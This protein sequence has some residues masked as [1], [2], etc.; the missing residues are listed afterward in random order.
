MTAR[1]LQPAGWPRPRGYSNG[2]VVEGRQVFLSGQVGWDESGRLVGD[3][4]VS[5]LRQALRNIVVL[6]ADAG[7]EP[8]HLVRMTWYLTNMM[9]YRAQQP[10]I[11]AAYRETIGRMYP[12]M[13]VVQVV[14]LAE[15]GACVEIEATAVVPPPASHMANP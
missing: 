1:T 10:G 11:G 13:S 8:R 2:V 9:D 15:P 3:D 6:L 4:L 14:T 12:P 7:A 5:Q